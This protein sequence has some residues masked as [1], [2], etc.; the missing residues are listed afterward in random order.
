VIISEESPQTTIGIA[1]SAKTPEDAEAYPQAMMNRGLLGLVYC[2]L[3]YGWAFWCPGQTN[4]TWQTVDPRYQHASPEAVERWRDL[5]YGLRICWGQYNVWNIEASWP[6]RNMSNA[7]KQEYF[8]LYKQFNPVDFNA[9]KWM[10]LL[11]RGGLKYFTILTKHH[12]GF[13]MYD[14]RTRVK[15]RINWTAP[16]GPSIEPCDLAYSIM[17]GPFR[18]DI[19]RELCDAAHRRGIAIDLYFSHCDWFDADFRG[20]PDHPLHDKTFSKQKD[21]EGYARMVTRHREQIREILTRYGGID[22]VCLDQSHLPGMDW[23]DMKETILLARSLQPDCL[24]RDRGI[25]AYGDYHTPEN[26]IPDSPQ[27]QESKSPWMVIFNLA[28]LYTYDP[29]AAN[30]KPGSWIVANLIDICAKGG[31]FMVILGPDAKGN[32]HPQAVKSLEYAGDWLR[33]NGEAIYGTRPWDKWK[34]GDSIRFTRTKD[35]NYVYA[36]S[37][38]WPGQTLK[39]KQVRPRAGSEVRML[40]LEQPLRWHLE[41]SEGFVIELPA[42]LQAEAA[43]PC[44]QAYVFKIVA[45]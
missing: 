40:G 2:G 42:E 34:E 12:D 31:N 15:R 22:M 25:G 36:I 32:F 17:D 27:D 38:K 20:D 23:A 44:K 7:R 11:N 33:V 37:L 43:R 45:P 24:F 21:P 9:D 10:D 4:D 19:I 3:L 41:P 26:R 28:G 13:S 14:T 6:L 16:G 39:L 29:I 30:Y 1:P 35:T 18:R 8:D 5:K